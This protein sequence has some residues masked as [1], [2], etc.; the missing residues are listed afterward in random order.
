MRQLDHRG[1]ALSRSSQGSSC[2]YIRIR[3]P[4]N[5]GAFGPRGRSSASTCVGLCKCVPDSD[6]PRG[7]D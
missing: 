2:V 4:E 6:E 7:A 3:Q 1:R 5:T